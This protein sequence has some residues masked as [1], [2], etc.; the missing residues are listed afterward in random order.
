VDRSAAA[1][2]LLR[3]FPEA[4]PIELQIR[5]QEAPDVQGIRHPIL[6]YVPT[7][8]SVG[9]VWTPDFK[10][11]YVADAHGFR[12]AEPWPMDPDVVVIGDSLVFGYGVERDQA[13]PQALERQLPG[14]RVLNLGLIGSGPQQYLRIYRHV[15]K[16]LAPK[17]VVV[18]FFAR[19]DFW[20]AGKFDEWLKEGGEG[21]YIVWRSR[22]GGST[23][24]R[25]LQGHSY[26]Y[27]L[28]QFARSATRRRAGGDP[29]LVEWV[30]GTTLQLMPDSA[31]R[32]IALARADTPTFALTK[33]AM[34]ELRDE[35]AADGAELL[36]V[37]QPSK[38]E[39][40]VSFAGLPT[41]DHAAT[42]R[43]AFDELGIDYLDL[44]PVFRD[45][46]DVGERL[47]YPTDGH[48]NAMGYQLTA[49]AVAGWIGERHAGLR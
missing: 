12:N 21:N 32:L 14:L 7:P 19:N 4:L 3:L 18:G 20:D 25:W 33:D 42:I 2:G 10:H 6:G 8:S 27:A 41:L 30:D 49:G 38:E 46:A 37:L 34:R 35:I 43:V 1:E 39:T 28:A 22:G 23:T 24:R 16:P 45:H 26:A 11:D 36:V 9:T 5:L 17:L 44:A 13:W 47:F 29:T 48:P 40:Y 15:A 31:A